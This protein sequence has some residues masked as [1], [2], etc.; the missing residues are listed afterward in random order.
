MGSFYDN[1][2]GMGPGNG[3]G[4]F[5]LMLLFWVLVAAAVFYFI[6]HSNHSHVDHHVHG[7]LAAPG[8]PPVDVLKM[9]FAKGEI[10]EEEF[11][12]RL[13]LLQRDK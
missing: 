7:P 2:W 9:R 6:R 10:D 8:E 4:M 11:S 3:L 5:I 1:R 13:A 12:K